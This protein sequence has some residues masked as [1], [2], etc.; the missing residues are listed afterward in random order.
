MLVVAQNRQ[1]HGVADWLLLAHAK[2]EGLMRNSK[3]LVTL[4]AAVML[5]LVTQ[6]V[7][8]QTPASAGDVAVS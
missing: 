7:W 2:M 6:D 3:L 4:S 5:G 1:S 8:A